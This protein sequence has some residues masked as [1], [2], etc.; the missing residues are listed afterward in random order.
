MNTTI[1]I[2][3]KYYEDGKLKETVEFDS[4]GKYAYLR[5][6]NDNVTI[7]DV[8]DELIDECKEQINNYL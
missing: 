6:T 7:N 1:S 4:I 5:E 8:K 3:I 2:E